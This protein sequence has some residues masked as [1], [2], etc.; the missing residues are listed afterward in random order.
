MNA[1]CRDGPPGHTLHVHQDGDSP[2]TDSRLDKCGFIRGIRR[3]PPQPG[4][5]GAATRCDLHPQSQEPATRG[6]DVRLHGRRP[7]GPLRR[8]G[9]A[10]T[11][12]GASKRSR[13][14]GRPRFAAFSVNVTVLPALQSPGSAAVRGARSASPDRTRSPPRPRRQAR[15]RAPA[16]AAPR[17]GPSSPAPAAGPGRAWPAPRRRH[18]RGGRRS[19]R[20]GAIRPQGSG[21]PDAPARRRSRPASQASANRNDGDRP[22]WPAI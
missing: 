21:C 13:P 15:P 6:A 3:L 17:G 22:A 10:R 14:A 5:R 2:W 20:H 8:A 9:G 19:R 16:S 7:R 11:G 18:G 12:A 4:G 1:L